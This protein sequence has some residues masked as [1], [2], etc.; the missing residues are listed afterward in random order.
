[1]PFPAVNLNQRSGTP[2]GR[3]HRL[4]LAPLGVRRWL[5]STGSLTRRLQRASDRFEVVRL[6]QQ[7]G[8]PCHDERAVV[9]PRERR[10]HGAAGAAGVRKLD[11]LVREVVLICDGQPAVFAHSVI[12]ARALAGRWRWLA[13]LGNRPLGAALFRDPRVRRGPLAYRRL[14]PPDPRFLGACRALRAAHASAAGGGSLAG[15]EQGA[16]AAPRALWARRSLFS[17]GGER[18]LVTEVF[19]PAVGGLAC[20]PA[21]TCIPA[22]GGVFTDEHADGR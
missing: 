17:A 9:A 13:G 18:L 7:R 12:S 10:G 1:M 16:F 2:D 20:A 3:W 15:P 14:R 22:T 5:T 11:F 19:L 21:P 4:A 6:R 8:A